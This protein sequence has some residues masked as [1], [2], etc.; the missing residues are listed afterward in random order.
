[1]TVDTVV[2]GIQLA[3]C[4]PFGERRL[5]F[6]H[7]L[8]RF[9]PIEFARL[10]GPKFL[11]ILLRPAAKLTMFDFTLD[12]GVAAKVCERRKLSGLRAGQIRYRG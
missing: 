7:P 9:E 6:Q 4:E 2:A 3:A 1:M 10:F 12:P 11:R 8:K 5:P